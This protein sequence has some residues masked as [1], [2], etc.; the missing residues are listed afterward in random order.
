VQFCLF[1]CHTGES[2]TLG[3]FISSASGS[4]LKMENEGPN[5]N[6]LVF[7]DANGPKWVSDN[8]IEA[9]EMKVSV[10]MKHISSL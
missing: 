1:L 10:I 9:A 7:S 6:K 3:S 5:A 8:E 2:L 4:S